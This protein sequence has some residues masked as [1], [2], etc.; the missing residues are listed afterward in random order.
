[1]T[2]ELCI[3]CVG[4]AYGKAGNGKRK[5]TWKAETDVENRAHAQKLLG[6]ISSSS[7]SDM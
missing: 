5:R 3:V 6:I 7:L 1:M 4:G 2:T